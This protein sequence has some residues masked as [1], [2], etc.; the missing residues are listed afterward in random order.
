MSGETVIYRNEMNLVPFRNFTSVEL[1]LFFAMCNKL[2]EQQSSTLHLSFNDLK[3]ISKYNHNQRNNKRFVE[4]L[5]H[6]YDK[7]LQI[8]Y[9]RENDDVIER[10]VLFN[11]YKI[12]K[13]EKYLEISTSPQ[14]IH[15][16]NSITADFTKFELEEVVSLKSSYSKNMFRLLKQ[17]KHT[18]FLKFKID[19][20][21]DRL[22]IPK[23]YQM[24]DI[25]KRVLKPIIKEL[26]ALFPNLHINKIKAPKGRKIAYIEF[27]FEAEKRIHSK[28]QH[29]KSGE[30][31]RPHLKS[32]ELT[33][34]W[35]E[36]REQ[37]DKSQPYKS[38][39]RPPTEKEQE[40]FK[41]YLEERWGKSE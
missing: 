12:H 10:F 27:I 30:K 32:R 40:E 26:G 16:L 39:S 36:D 23:S 37:P 14:L 4:D 25:N 18:G 7:M 24:N 31:K 2:K 3:T 35:L 28:K 22:D 8:T 41:K 17:Y 6:V 13:S 38:D 1:D 15:I 33:P 20:F 21:R 11:H 29:F 5:Q 34:K 19:D 9:K